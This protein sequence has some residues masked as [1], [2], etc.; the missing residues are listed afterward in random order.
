MEYVLKGCLNP[1]I[2]RIVY[3][4]KEILNL[5]SII[6]PIALIVFLIIDLAKMVISGD[7]K[8][9]KNIKVIINRIVFSALIFFVPTIVSVVMNSIDSAGIDVG[10]KNDYNDY[11]TCLKNANKE[12]ID[13]LQ[14]IQ[15][16]LE[17]IAEKKRKE[18]MNDKL[19]ENGDKYGTNA[20]RGNGF[21]EGNG[22]FGGSSDSNN[23]LTDEDY[24]GVE[25]TGNLYQDLAN[26][27]IEVAASEIG[28]TE[29]KKETKKENGDSII[30][31]HTKYAES[32]HNPN[33]AWCSAFVM[34]VA[35]NTSVDNTNLFNDVI[36]KEGKIS[37]PLSATNSIYTFSNNSNLNF[38][39]S[40]AYGG[41]YTPKKGDLIYFYYNG[42]WDKQITS[43]MH[44][45]DP[46]PNDSISINGHVEIV[47]SVN[48]NYITTIG[49][50][51]ST[52][53]T[54]TINGQSYSL[55]GV[56]KTTN[57]YTLDS[58]NIIGYGS[59]YQ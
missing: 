34:W 33:V 27:M 7:E 55:R 51:N 54:A 21:T 56:T 48:G 23:P 58:K 57:Y 10:R 12:T 13:E 17:A 2:L 52:S 16:Q 1:D 15:D 43:T 5:L 20:D 22:G 45:T 26:R 6:I 53:Q 11:N 39:Y 24:A 3:L 46:N 30:T 40:K 29:T 19:N 32:F 31:R 9:S 42:T 14:A 47:E 25:G 37:N 41:D 4:A 35:K 44:L 28:Y 50:N 49:G 18:E 8:Q 36:Q 38:Y 59:W